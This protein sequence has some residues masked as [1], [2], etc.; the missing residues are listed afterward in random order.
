MRRC[1]SYPSETDLANLDRHRYR[2]LSPLVLR[3][4]R[5]TGRP[6]RTTRSSGRLVEGDV[7]HRCRLFFDARLPARHR[8]SRRGLPVSDRHADSRPAH[9]VWR[10]SHLCARG[11][12]QPARAGQHFHARGSAPTL[13]RQSLRP[14]AARVCGNGLRHHHHAFSRRRHRT[15]RAQPVR[16]GRA[17]PSNQ[18]SRWCC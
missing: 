2:A 10:P 7:P 1:R 16:A 9:A 4:A 18:A 8:L 17:E 12:P 5:R 6:S 11:G 3:R 15:Y 14:R 13:A